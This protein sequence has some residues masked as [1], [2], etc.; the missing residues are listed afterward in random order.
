MKKLLLILPIA[1]A[2]C[3][4]DAAQMAA[5]QTKKLHD[6]QYDGCMRAIRNAQSLGVVNV[7]NKTKTDYC[8]CVADQMVERVDMN[9]IANLI[10]KDLP[11]MVAST[12]EQWLDGS[13]SFCDMKMGVKL[14]QN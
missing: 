8:K 14:M 6:G 5:V 1:L 13:M 3:G 2:I 7:S 9:I 12:M 4:A 10:K 11:N